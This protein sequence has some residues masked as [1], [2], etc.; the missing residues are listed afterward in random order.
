MTSPL[1][2][3]PF[4]YAG[5]GAVRLRNDDQFG[6]PI[7]IAPQNQHRLSAARVE[8]IVNLRFD[9]LLASSLSLFREALG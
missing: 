5:D 9:G 8:W 2:D 3:H 7:G 1:L 4:G 6:A